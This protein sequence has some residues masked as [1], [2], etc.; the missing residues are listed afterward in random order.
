MLNA[1]CV[2]RVLFFKRNESGEGFNDD[3]RYISVSS[4]YFYCEWVTG[5]CSTSRRFVHSDFDA[6][7]RQVL[8]LISMSDEGALTSRFFML[9]CPKGGLEVC[10]LLVASEM[11]S[12]KRT[13]IY[14]NVVYV[15]RHVDIEGE[16]YQIV[17]HGVAEQ[18][19]IDG[20]LKNV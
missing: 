3:F 5:T 14:D 17:C 6:L 1:V 10:W 15:L 7:G 4:G 8:S 16:H 9:P 12:D 19:E 2:G 13:L 11:N 20:F 18:H